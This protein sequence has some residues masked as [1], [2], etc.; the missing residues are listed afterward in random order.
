MD[1]SED[2]ILTVRGSCRG[3]YDFTGASV[4]NLDYWFLSATA[5]VGVTLD[6]WD[7]DTETLLVQ[8][9]DYATSKDV[10]YHFIHNNI[11]EV[12]GHR[13]CIIFSKGVSG[14]GRYW[15]DIHV[16]AS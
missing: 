3:V 7:Q 4:V 14:T 11:T 1:L 8:F 12:L 13:V 10:W 6:F 16:E 2:G 9:V 5:G 15:D